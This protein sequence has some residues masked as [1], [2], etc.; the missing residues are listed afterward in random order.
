M[1]FRDNQ[2]KPTDKQAKFLSIPWSIREALYGG[3]AGSG[4]SELLLMLP[5]VHRFHEN[6]RYKQ[7]LLRR[8]HKQLK[9]EIVP[10]SQEIYPKFG[11]RLNESD[12]VW[13]FPRLDQYGSGAKPTGAQVWLGHCENENDV[14]IYDSMEINLFTPDEITSL[15][16]YIYLYIG[17]TRVR[18]SDPTLPA[19]IRAAGM[20][21]DVGH[22]FVKSRFIDYAPRGEVIIEGK[23]GNKRIYIHS[24]LMDNPHIDPNYLQGL[25]ALPEAEKQAKL[26]G[27][28]DAYLGQ[29]F[30]EFRDRHYED[31]PPNAL[32]VID[33]ID[34]PVWWPRIVVIDWGFKALTYALYGAISPDKRLYIYREQAF[35]G[36]KIEEW[37]GYVKEHIIEELPKTVKLCRSASQERG[38]EH[39]V[40]Q[41]VEDALGVSVE[42]TNN[43]PGTRVAGKLIVHEYLRWKEKYVPARKI[44]EYDDDRA[45][46]ILRNEGMVSYKR[47]L[48]SFDAPETEKNLPKLQIFN[49]CPYLIQAIKSCTYD[50]N[51][52]EDVAAF[53]GDDPYDAIRYMVDAADR[54][55][56]ESSQ[57][58]QRIQQIGNIIHDLERS[59]DWNKYYRVMERVESNS[60]NIRPVQRYHSARR[61]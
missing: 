31:E 34:I 5:I 45:A 25:M 6:S 56:E 51:K 58:F 60:G 18:T 48:K 20:P 10:R 54:Y 44:S 35:K 1:P 50:K 38:Q 55:F 49:T 40:H 52:I 27:S 57:E 24:T 33:P 9:K 11:A 30:E 39:T 28:W 59:N 16:E 32:H 46:W 7:V 42:A 4:K 2:W 22:A 23:G 8:T 15:T 13:T 17:F 61:H 43:S 41:Q 3:G 53:D 37:A 36:V 14:H 29:V 47:Y 26:Y 21:G 12:M 19:C